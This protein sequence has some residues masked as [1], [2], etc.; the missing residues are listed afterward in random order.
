MDIVRVGDDGIGVMWS[1]GGTMGVQRKEGKMNDKLKPC[2][3][4]GGKAEMNKIEYE[5]YGEDVA[6]YYVECFSCCSSSDRYLTD[7]LAVDAWNRRV[8]NNAY[9]N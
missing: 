9:K 2:P 1:C 6:K 4:C 3:F 7:R 5:Y 8:D